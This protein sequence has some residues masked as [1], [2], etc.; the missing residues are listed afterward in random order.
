MADVI[1]HTSPLPNSMFTF[2]LSEWNEPGIA[3][4]MVSAAPSSMPLLGGT[5]L[6]D[7][8]WSFS[9]PNGAIWLLLPGPKTEYTAFMHPL[10]SGYTIYAQAAAFDSTQSQGFAFSNGLSISIP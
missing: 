8:Q 1:A 4:L 6:V 9:G 3:F 2:E 10:V 5:L 7:P